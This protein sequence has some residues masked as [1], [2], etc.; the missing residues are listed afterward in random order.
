M[1]F[2]NPKFAHLHMG[3]LCFAN[4]LI[5]TTIT[6]GFLMAYISTVTED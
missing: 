2:P 1:G 5:T 6:F 3:V 4:A